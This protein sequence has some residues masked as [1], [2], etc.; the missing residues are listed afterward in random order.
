MKRSL[1]VA[2]VLVAT[3]VLAGPIEARQGA[4]DPA[5]AYDRCECD[6]VVDAPN[7]SVF[8]YRR[9]DVGGGSRFT[10]DP[11]SDPFPTLTECLQYMATL[12]KCPQHS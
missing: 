4:S 5:L 11:L 12:A 9:V 1:L 6:D 2:S 10:V 3:P 8:G 7:W